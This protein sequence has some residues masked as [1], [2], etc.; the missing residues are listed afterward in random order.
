MWPETLYIL[1]ASHFQNHQS[2]WFRISILNTLVTKH[3]F[4]L[5]TCLFVLP[6][7]TSATLLA[8]FPI[9]FPSLSLK[10]HLHEFYISHWDHCLFF[11][12]LANGSYQT[13]AIPKSDSLMT[14]LVI[15]PGIPPGHFTQQHDS[16]GSIEEIQSWYGS[17]L[18]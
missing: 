2:R 1:K 12:R 13:C 14:E 11:I 15:S 7:M 6:T 10:M 17:V 9:T 3:I 18:T 8:C 4:Y 16:T 5:T